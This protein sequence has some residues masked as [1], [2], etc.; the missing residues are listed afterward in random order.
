MTL[1]KELDCALS[2]LSRWVLGLNLRK[3][4]SG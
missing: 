1:T 3:A 4:Q 2:Q